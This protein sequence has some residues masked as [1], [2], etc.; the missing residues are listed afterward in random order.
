MHPPAWLRALAQASMGVKAAE[1]HLNG[2][3]LLAPAA[4]LAHGLVD[5]L[6]DSSE[7]LALE[8]REELPLLA[9]RR[10]APLANLPPQAF[11]ASKRGGRFPI[12]DLA[13]SESVELFADGGQVQI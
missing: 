13:G 8:E 7:G 4:A 9:A 12:A 6:V 11:K 10:L 1:R 3:T 2:A 5:E